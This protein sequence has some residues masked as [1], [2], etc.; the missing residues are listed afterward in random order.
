MRRYSWRKVFFAFVAA[1]GMGVSAPAAGDGSA[2]PTAR[3]RVFVIPIHGPIEP[4]LLYVIRRG[5]QEAADSGVAAV[6]FSMNTPGG[7]VDV[8]QEIISAIGHLDMPTFTFV[9]RDA[10]SAGALIALSTDKIYMAEGGK[11]GDA[12]PIGMLPV[13]GAQ[14]IPGDLREKAEA[15]VSAIARSA[16]EQGGHRK[17]VAEAMVRRDVGLKIGETVICPPGQLLTLT[18]REAEQRF[19]GR[20]LLSEGT[21]GS[22]SEMLAA[23]GLAY[24]EIT[25]LRVTSAERFAR[26]IAALGPL[27]FIAGALGLYIEFKTP[28]FGLPGIAGGA[29]LAIYFWGHHVAGLAGYEDILIFALGLAL[30]LVEVFVLPGFGIAGIAGIALVLLSLFMAMVQRYPGQPYWPSYAQA[31]LPM[32]KMT[33][34]L[35]GTIAGAVLLAR[36]L[37]KTPLFRRLVLEKTTDR[38]AGFTAAPTRTDLVGHAGQALSDLRPAGAAQFGGERLDVMTDGRFIVRGT[39]VKIVKAEGS[40]IFVEESPD[41]GGGQA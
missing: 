17:E 2:K 22:L 28:G 29:C 39:R 11:I 19:D 36:V 6:V 32:L 13:V 8:T 35:V 3:P 9:E 14:E 16:A 27:F 40:R 33:L 10:F 31:R 21:V 24:P 1:L 12:M 23:A 15:A 34:S 18:N 37:P 30:I 38:A 20:P 26:W 25:E 5:V 7:R 41:A 4:A